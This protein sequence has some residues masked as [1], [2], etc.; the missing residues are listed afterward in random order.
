MLCSFCYS[1]SHLFRFSLFVFQTW[2]FSLTLNTHGCSACKKIYPRE[3]WTNTVLRH[4][5]YQKTPL[6]CK[7]C[8]DEGYSARDF[9]PIKCTKCERWRGHR[10]FE[11]RRQKDNRKRMGTNRTCICIDC[12]SKEKCDGCGVLMEKSAIKKRELKYKAEH[13]K[14]KLLCAKCIAE[15]LTKHD[16]AKYEC[17]SCGQKRG[18]SAFACRP[19]NDWLQARNTKLE[20]A[21]CVRKIAD[22]LKVLEKKLKKSKR[23]CNCYQLLHASKC[24]LTPC[25]AGERRWPGSDGYINGEEMQFLNS[26]TPRPEWW[27]RAC[28]RK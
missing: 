25:Y 10:K 8:F 22:R 27:V 14:S 17:T 15:G 28:G 3:Q 7:I 13:P 19:L 26:R 20:C 11:D 16:T 6:I 5:R 4:H 2:K 9:N 18:R 12:E 21:D 23:V 1:G 24:P